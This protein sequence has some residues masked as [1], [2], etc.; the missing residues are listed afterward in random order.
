[1]AYLF[2]E[3]SYGWFVSTFCRGYL[4]ESV[5]AII[6]IFNQGAVISSRRE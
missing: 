4:L 5:Q 3:E 6:A 2:S 1:M